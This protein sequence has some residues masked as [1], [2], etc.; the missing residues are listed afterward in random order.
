MVDLK[1]TPYSLSDEDIAWVNDT[2]RSMT[3]EEKAGQLFCPFGIMEDEQYRKDLTEK[4]HVGGIMCR[5]GP[6]DDISAIHEQLQKS[7]KIPLLLASNLESG[8]RGQVAEGTLF[9]TQ[10]QVAATAEPE[11]AYHLGTICAREAS[12]VGGNWAF[13][14]VMDLNMNFRSP[15]TNTRTYGSNP[16]LVLA[17]GKAYLRGLQENQVAG[18]AKHFPGDGMDDR[19]QHLLSSINSCSVEEWDATYGLVYKGMIDA[20]IQTIMVGH[21][22]LPA[23]SKALRPGI[24]DEDIMPATLAPEI[25]TDLL[26]GKLGFNG[27]II[28]DAT[29]MAGFTQF[30]TREKAVPYS[31]MAGADMFLFNLGLKD[32]YRF[33]LRGIQEGILTRERLD[34]AVTR[35]L[36]TKAA[37]GLHKKQKEGT[38][39]G[40]NREVLGC[41]EHQGWVNECADKAITLVKNKQNI[42]PLSLDKFR[43]I[44]LVVLGESNRAGSH[45]GGGNYS[46]LFRQKLEQEGF[47][48]TRFHPEK[49][50]FGATQLF[51]DGE[52]F[53]DPYD[54]ILYYAN[55]GTYSSATEVRVHWSPNVQ[56]DSVRFLQ[57]KPHAFVSVS[58]P[59][60]LQ[61]VPRVPVYIN[62]Y[63]SSEEI[64]NN[65][66]EKLMGRSEFK[67]VSPVDP[68]CGYWDTRL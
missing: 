26:R 20:G 67:G 23:Y 18:S 52:H 61:D 31:I 60:H 12:V 65:L 59:Y 48:V 30:M 33:M 16:E 9:G 34:E 42:L 6:C 56:I 64:V 25:M 41:M 29:T 28:T 40:R 36:G 50:E 19:D 55:E 13:A 10:L 32:D 39:I 22:M 7:S 1:K 57:D 35:I 24:A 47:E 3:L 17:M 66:V 11:Q 44:L 54:L 51:R 63:T 37:L 2:L 43:K 38:L 14:P 15:I 58:W 8:G 45:S 27:M 4:Y 21:I 5:P 53:V 46:E 68:F 62:C 49:E